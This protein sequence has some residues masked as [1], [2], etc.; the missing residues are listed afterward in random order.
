MLKM[1]FAQRDITPAGSVKMVGFG[2]ADEWSRGVE[3]PLMAQLAVWESGEEF[4]CLAAVDSIGFSTENSGRLRLAVGEALGISPERVMLCFSHTH[5]AP[6]E[7][8]SPEYFSL[9]RERAAE[10]ARE[11]AASMEEVWSASGRARAELGVNR[12]GGA[13]D[14]RIGILLHTSPEGV[15]RLVV[16][17]VAAHCNCLKADNYLLSPDYFGAVRARFSQR[18]GCPVIVTQGAAGDVAPKF[19]KSNIAVPDGC[20][21]RS[22]RSEEALE[23]MAREAL[24]AAVPVIERLE[25]EADDYL[26]VYSAGTRLWS[27]VPTREEAEATA[28]EAMEACG[29][30]GSAWLSEVARLGEEGID[31][32]SEEVEAQY[33]T[34]GGFTLCGV[35][36]EIMC[37]TAMRL[38]ERLN[39]ADFYFGGYTNGSAGY[40]PMADEFDRGGY[41][42]FWS[43]LT[44]WPYFHRVWPLRRDSERRLEELVSESRRRRGPFG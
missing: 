32:I 9:V 22:I 24:N 42:V 13:T 26:A 29:I 23:D 39:D 5:S 33:L 43:L 6:D 4:A 16:M 8:A 1:G 10:A 27:D 14:D 2:R 17:R 28:R 30:D 38:T 19:Y 40:L 34:V 35:P 18:Y 37:R 12:R 3:S 44:Y 21:G 41:E 15:P 31:E 20:D 25:P 36:H 7:S 11:A